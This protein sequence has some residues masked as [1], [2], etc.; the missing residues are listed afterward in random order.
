[1][2][3]ACSLLGLGGGLIMPFIQIPLFSC[4]ICYFM[5]LFGGRWLIQ[6]MDYRM[7][8]NTTRIIVFGLLLGMSFSCLSGYPLV[9]CWMISSSIMHG[10]A[11]L[12]DVL[13]NAVCWL[14]CPLAFIFGVL[15]PTVYGERW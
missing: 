15:R 1:M 3:G 4:V 14:F 2:I 10:G 7:G 8:E 6:F 11:G 9:V 13:A 5:G 12:F